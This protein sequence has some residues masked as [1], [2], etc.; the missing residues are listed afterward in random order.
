MSRSINDLGETLLSQLNEIATGGDDTVSSSDDDFIAWCQPGI[1]FDAD[2]FDF[3]ESGLGTGATA[4]DE[5]KLIQHAYNFSQT[6]DFIPDASGLYKD[7]QQQ[8]IFRTSGARL[9]FMYGEILRLCRVVDSELS[10]EE[11]EKLEKYRKFLFE[12]KTKKNLVT[13]EET[14]VTEAGP[15]MKAYNATMAEYI[16][17]AMLYNSAK[18]A[19]QGA[20]GPEG[21]QAVAHFTNNAQ[22]LRLKVKAARDKWIAEGYRNEVD[23]INAYINAVTSRSMQSWKQRLREYHEAGF[24]DALGPSQ[25]FYYAS[26]I[27]GNFAKGG[28]WTTYSLYHDEKSSTQSES[29]KSWKAGG[30]FGWG[31]FSVGGG[32]ER[33]STGSSRE[34]SVSSFKISFEFAQV[35][36]SRPGFYPEFFMNRGW[37]LEPGHGWHFEDMPSDGKEQPKGVFVGYPTQILFIRNLKI[38]SKEFASEYEKIVKS[39]EGKGSVGWGPF[40]LKGGHTNK[41]EN[42]SFK[43]TSDGSAVKADGMQIIGFINHR[44]GKAPNPADGLKPED[45]S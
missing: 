39:T 45:F 23:D 29:R 26:V 32:G 25:R 15:V 35:L 30:K 9:S 8:A 13:E 20:T 14:T 7:D 4:E 1:P 22:L 43:S 11:S 6:V 19:A 12:T 31:L 41:Q 24:M 44:L 28:G 38:E 10:A 17:A 21:R 37:T 36:I 18:V 16:D 5:K 40:K 2:D 3:A 27:P 42:K 34:F 33:S